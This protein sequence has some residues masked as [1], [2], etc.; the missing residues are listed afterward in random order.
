MES[1]ALIFLF[2]INSADQV[3]KS[4]FRNNFWSFDLSCLHA[5]IVVLF[6][7]VVQSVRSQS[8]ACSTILSS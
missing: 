8:F 4:T 5:H 7:S 1:A 2:F 3:A 6:P